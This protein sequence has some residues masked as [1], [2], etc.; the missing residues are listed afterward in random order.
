[1]GTL[2]FANL[3]SRPTEVLDFTSLTIEEFRELA[4]PFEAAFKAQRATWCLD[5][6]PRAARRYTTCTNCPLPMPEDRLLFIL[7][8]LKTYPLQM[9]QGRLFGM[10]QSKTH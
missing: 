3:Q 6:R 10:G 2:Q 5:G 7:V 4:P 8:Y 1:M 9:V